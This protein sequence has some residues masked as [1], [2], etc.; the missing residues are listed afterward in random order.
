M[1]RWTLLGVVLVACVGF[2]AGRVYPQAP[3]P[4]LRQTTAHLNNIQNFELRTETSYRNFYVP[5]EWGHLVAVQ[6]IGGTNFLLFFQSA[7]GPV[8]IVNGVLHGRYLYIDTSD[9]G[10]V[11]VYVPRTP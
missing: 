3:M 9:E 8:Y 6:A 2:A 10:G 7:D 5:Y 4:P 1:R 11:T